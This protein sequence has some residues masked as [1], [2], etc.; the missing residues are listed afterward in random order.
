VEIN[1]NAK[2][3]AVTVEGFQGREAKHI[4]I[5][6]VRSRADDEI[7]QRDIRRY[8]G[9]VSNPREPTL[10]SREPLTPDLGWQPQHVAAR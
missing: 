3:R 1:S 9:F 5:T 4:V 6:C 8:L 2:V 7:I 10:P